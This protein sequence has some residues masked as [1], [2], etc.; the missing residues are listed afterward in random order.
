MDIVDVLESR[1][2]RCSKASL[3]LSLMPKMWGWCMMDDIVSVV[4]AVMAVKVVV[5]V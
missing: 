4:V 3:F 5:F 1:L 2:W